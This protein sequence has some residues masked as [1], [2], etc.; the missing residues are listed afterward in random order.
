M[1]YENITVETH[2]GAGIV[3]FNRPDVLNALSIALWRELDQ[4]LTELEANPDVG[5]IVVTGRGDRAFSAGADIHEMARDAENASPSYDDERAGFVW[6]IATCQKPTVGA[7]NGLAYGGGAVIASSLDIRVGNEKSS[8]RFLAASYG[9]INSTWSLPLQVGWPAA[10]DLLFTARV[11][12]AREAHQI[13]LLNHLVASDHLMPKALEVAKTIAANDQR[14]VQGI[15]QLMIENVGSV[16]EDMYRR[17]RS[18]LAG[19]LKPTLVEEGF[20]DFLDRKGRK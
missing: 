5:A 15:K 10:K 13:G 4:A 2:D 7:I 17:E 6:H 11:I 19:E 9:R 16:W 3:T 1:A 8:F 14:M 18:A 12:G 20:K